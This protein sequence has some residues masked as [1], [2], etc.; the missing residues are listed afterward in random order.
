MDVPLTV[1]SLG[2]GRET[3]TTAD[4]GLCMAIEHSGTVSDL[5]ATLFVAVEASPKAAYE[6]EGQRCLATKDA[7][8]KVVGASFA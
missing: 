4:E 1:L 8:G 6:I 5:H 3:F 7:T 2:Q